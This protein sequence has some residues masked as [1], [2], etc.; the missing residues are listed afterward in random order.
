MSSDSKK[1]Q[2]K[3]EVTKKVESKKEA[4]KKTEAA[5]SPKKAPVESK[6]KAASSPAKP[7]S[8]KAAAASPKKA[9]KEAKPAAAASKGSVLIKPSAADQPIVITPRRRV[10]VRKDTAQKLVEVPAVRRPAMPATLAARKKR[11]AERLL[12]EAQQMLEVRK[13]RRTDRR[14]FAQRAARYER[15]YRDAERR[16]VSARRQ[17]KAGGNFYLEAEPKMALVIRIRGI[18]G[19]PPKQR[20]ILQLLRLR[21]INNAVF[22]RLSKPMLNMLKLVDP[23]I[24]WG[25]PSLAT[26]RHLL[27]KR[28][29]LRINGAR[30]AIS[31]NALI[32]QNSGVD[33]IECVEDLVHEIYT[34][35]PNFRR[36]NNF[37]WPFKLQPPRG[38]YKNTLR[39]VNEGGD[40]GY[41]ADR[42]TALARQMI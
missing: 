17:A 4:P 18:M 15:E 1:Q 8:S 21:Q 24:T 41:R 23:Y 28:A 42:I 31:D 9:P 38:G 34:V 7:T 10:V 2:A 22:V 40:F 20:K 30:I 35:G 6:S 39:H 3:K 27:Y 19:L 37:L 29:H 36:V 11:T 14:A 33:G 13:K 25:S 5:S 26:V 12:S 32:G 16:V